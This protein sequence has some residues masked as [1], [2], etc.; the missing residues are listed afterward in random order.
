MEG[1]AGNLMAVVPMPLVDL[2]S[3]A[4]LKNNSKA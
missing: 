3:F 2:F 4:Y 1:F